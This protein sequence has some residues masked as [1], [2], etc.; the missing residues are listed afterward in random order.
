MKKAGKPGSEK[1][2]DALAKVLAE[3]RGAGAP[4]AEAIKLLREASKLSLSS[5]GSKV[6]GRFGAFGRGPG[7]PPGRFPSGQGYGHNQFGRDYYDGPP[8][9]LG[10]LP[11]SSG[12]PGPGA[13]G[14]KGALL[15]GSLPDVALVPNK[16]LVPTGSAG[17]SLAA[18]PH[19][20]KASIST[21]QAAYLEVAKHSAEPIYDDD[22]PEEQKRKLVSKNHIDLIM[23]HLVQA[24]GLAGQLQQRYSVPMTEPLTHSEAVD[25]AHLLQQAYKGQIPAV[26]INPHLKEEFHHKKL[27]AGKKLSEYFPFTL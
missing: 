17:Q 23:H 11:P 19:S 27:A 1:D 7:G 24:V 4:S 5:Q 13:L 6:D 2:P 8:P 3:K 9:G 10:G 20:Q 25:F 14:V 12:K 22:S 18:H 21:L 26:P 15:A 16:I